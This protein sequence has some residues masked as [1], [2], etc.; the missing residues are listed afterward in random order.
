MKRS[1]D[2]RLIIILLAAVLYTLSSTAQGFK[3]L[4]DVPHDIAYYR[5]SKM[6]TPLVKVLYGRPSHTRNTEIFGTEVPFN[7]IWRTGANEATEIKIYKDVM[8]GDKL[9]SAGTYVIY[10]IPN[11][12]QW[13]I[14]LSSN[15]DVLGAHQ[16]DLV[17]DVARIQVPVAK[18]E[19]ITTFSI[20]FKKIAK[21]NIS[22]MFAWGA[23]RAKVLLDFNEQEY[24]AGIY[25]PKTTGND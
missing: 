11:K 19:R 7:E 14:I 12:N 22:M 2:L 16:Y 24:Y 8:F 18:G 15:T 9:V 17:F 13:E 4:D 3:K 10:T 20:G 1:F 21:N 5:A 23:T 6:T 25:N